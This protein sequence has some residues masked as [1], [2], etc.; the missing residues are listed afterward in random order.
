MIQTRIIQTTKESLTYNLSLVLSGLGSFLS[1]FELDSNLR[2]AVHQVHQSNANRFRSNQVQWIEIFIWHVFDTVWQA[3]GRYGTHSV[4]RNAR[5]TN[6][7]IGKDLEF[8]IGRWE[9][10]SFHYSLILVSQL[11][12]NHFEY[13]SI[14]L[15]QHLYLSTVFLLD[16]FFFEFD[17][18]TKYKQEKLM[19]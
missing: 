7:P 14:L 2:F 8:K 4:Q 18:L 16:V 17:S 3:F 11:F 12:Q 1:W 19:K 13:V 9:N 10:Q 6:P 5:P 15:C